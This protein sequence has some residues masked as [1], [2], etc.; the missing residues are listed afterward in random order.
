MGQVPKFLIVGNGRLARHLVHYFALERLSFVQWA[1]STSLSTDFST[2]QISHVLLGLSDQAIEPFCEQYQKQLQGRT[3]VH[4]SGAL[5]TPFAIGAHP[6]MTFSHDLYEPEIYRKM[7]FVCEKDLAELLPGIKN[8]FYLIKPEDKALYHAWCVMSGNFTT[9]LWE[10][11]AH[12]LEDRL[13]ISAQALL[14][15]LSQIHSNLQRSLAQK[16]GSVLT[17]PLVRGDLQTIKKNIDSLKAE[18]DAFGKI[19]E[20]FVEAWPHLC[21]EAWPHRN[22]EAVTAKGSS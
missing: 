14:P 11:F 17:G 20:A 3:V 4:F 12:R 2:E 19:Y 5:N 22:Q 7:S 10:A 1:R 8:T 18:G 9:I 16:S 15:Y 21:Q 6:L 13:Q